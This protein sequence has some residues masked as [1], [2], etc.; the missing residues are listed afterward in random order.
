MY[1]WTKVFPKVVGYRLFRALNF[2]KLMPLSMTLSV[3]NQCNSRCKTCN[4]WKLYK[5]NP[6][7]RQKEL[8]LQEFRSIF[9]SIG[10]SA[11]WFTLSGGEPFLRT[12]LA[13]I[14][15]SL[16]DNCSP[17][18]LSIPTNG[19]LP[20][21]IAKTVKRILD[22]CPK[23]SVILT[24]SLDG[25]KHFHDEVRGV[26]RNFES[27]M[28]TYGLL[29]ELQ[30]QYDNL[31]VDVHTV[32][33]RF[34]VDRLQDVYDFV[35]A[36]MKPDSYISEIAENRSELLNQKDAIAPDVLSYER[37]IRTLR[38]NIKSDYL[39][40]SGFPKLIQAFRLEYYNLVVE[41][42]KQRRQILP[43]YAGF[44]S[45]Q[46][47]V[48]ADV[49]PCCIL[50]YDASM[51]NLREHDYD[52]RKVWFSKRADEVRRMIKAGVCYCPMANAHYT[53]MLCDTVT[54]LKVARNAVEFSAA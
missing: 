5:E 20:R 4:V 2:P 51:G 17:S 8:S 52:F 53:N 14:A 25:V 38:Q 28:E 23:S 54:L 6:Q 12:D 1:R 13:D 22:A 30:R 15:K 48:Y 10:D 16:Y 24:L 18:V 45:C 37:A 35:K 21:S 19:L 11:V 36:E 34:N 32:V 41:E 46:I 44:A 9:R 26:P 29:K 27:A 50:A 33:S 7:L 49:W 3:T 43:C 47:S 39:N 31:E 42:L 40:K